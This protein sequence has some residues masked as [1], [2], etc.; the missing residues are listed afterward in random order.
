ML[1]LVDPYRVKASKP[2][3]QVIMASS[4]RQGTA[5]RQE[6]VVLTFS[7]ECVVVA[8]GLSTSMHGDIVAEVA[9]ETALW[10]YQH[11]RLHPSFWVDK[12][13]FMKRIFR[14]AN[15][16][17]WQKLREKECAGGAQTT[18]T[19]AMIGP[20]NVFIGQAGDTGAFL[21]REG[22]LKQLV[23]FDRTSDGLPKHTLGVK[24]L[25]LVHEFVSSEFLP[26]DVLL[27]LTDGT[28]EHVDNALLK[29]IAEKTGGTT[30]SLNAAVESLLDTVMKRGGKSNMSAVMVKRLPAS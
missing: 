1:R 11:I 16:T 17:V 28:W 8:D 14:T 23:S 3:T 9:A 22:N 26:H 27:L 2:K 20:L 21:Y 10:A 15:M 6:D 5:V 12:K 4:T 13:L 19:V 29:S 18:L 30:E 25:G 24:R 7:D